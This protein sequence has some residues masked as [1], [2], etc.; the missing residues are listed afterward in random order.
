MNEFD[1]T[2]RYENEFQLLSILSNCR[3][4]V[5]KIKFSDKYF[6][7][8]FYQKIYRYLKNEK[9]MDIQL[10]LNYMSIDDAKEFITKIYVNN[11]YADCDKESMALSYAKLI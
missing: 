7:S 4:I 10:M 1:I 8:E 2:R 11:L 6:K 5:D 9:S 3:K